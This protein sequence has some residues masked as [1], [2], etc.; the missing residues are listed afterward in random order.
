MGSYFV[1]TNLK[2]PLLFSSATTEARKEKKHVK[3]RMRVFR[4]T[5][6]RNVTGASYIMVFAKRAVA[7]RKETIRVIEKPIAQCHHPS[8]RRESLSPHARPDPRKLIH[9]CSLDHL[10]L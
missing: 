2:S 5:V 9:P 6:E 4:E 10:S 3:H 8:E 1:S 7:T